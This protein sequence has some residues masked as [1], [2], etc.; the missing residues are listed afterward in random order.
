M[1]LGVW[2]RLVRRRFIEWV[3]LNPFAH[4]NPSHLGAVPLTGGARRHCWS[5]SSSRARASVPESEQRGEQCKVTSV[6]T[7]K[8]LPLRALIARRAAAPEVAV[9]SS[10]PRSARPWQQL[11]P[12]SGF[13]CFCELSLTKHRGAR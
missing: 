5:S 6:T 12:V 1:Y 8:R 10:F 2:R 9:V 13:G 3:R 4:L 7:F 11:V